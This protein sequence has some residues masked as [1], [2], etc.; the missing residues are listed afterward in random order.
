[1][2]AAEKKEEKGRRRREKKR[3]KYNNLILKFLR[4]LL[5]KTFGKISALF[6]CRK[7]YKVCLVVNFKEETS[8]T[9]NWFF[10]V[11]FSQVEIGNLCRWYWSLWQFCCWKH[12]FKLR[13]MGLSFK[14][15]R[16]FKVW[17]SWPFQCTQVSLRNLILISRAWGLVLAL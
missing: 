1:M 12:I 17:I 3:Q 8:M 14:L 13:G 16:C 5:E 9:R 6:I 2:V 7:F 15:K 4:C 11:S 10:K